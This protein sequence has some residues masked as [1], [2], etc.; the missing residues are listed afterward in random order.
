M[1]NLGKMLLF[2]VF[3]SAAMATSHAQV[4]R[5]ELERHQAPVNF[6]NFEGPVI[7]NETR[8]QI[9]QIGV[10]LGQDIAAGQTQAGTLGWYFVISSVS[11]PD[12]D[13][14]NAD[15]FGIGAGAAVDH[16][17]N[18]RVIIQGY[19]QAAYNY[20]EADAALLSQFI[21]IY[22]AVNRADWDFIS[23]RYKAPV[24][25]HLTPQN[26]GISV[27]FDEW[28]GQ[29]RMLIPIAGMGDLSAVDTAAISDMRVIDEL[30]TE[31]GM[32]IE[33]RMDLVDLMEREAAE[34]EARAAALR[35]AAALEEQA[36]AQE[37][38]RLEAEQQRIA[39]EQQQLA[40]A[41]AASEVTPAQA[42]QAQAAIAQAQAAAAAQEQ[43]I[44]QQEAAVAAQQAAAAQQ[45]QF[46]EQRFDDA[47]QHREAIAQ[48][49]QQIIIAQVGLPP[50][51]PPTLQQGFLTV[52]IERPG[53]TMGRLVSIDP[54]TRQQRNSPLTTVQARTLTFVDGRLLAIAGER[55]GQ[56]AVRL[57]EIDTRNMEMVSQG[58]DDIHPGSLIWQN[59]MYLYAI[60]ADHANG[61]ALNLG[62]FDRNLVL[63]ARSD[64]VLH[65]NASISIQQGSLMTQRAD[66]TAA[67]LHPAT[68]A[69]N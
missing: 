44:A 55:V 28:A 22:N 65:P 67:V 57:V 53:S 29:T 23:G 42:A 46:A 66:G 31:D 34:A 39:Q 43:A 32:G 41:Q 49:Q 17:R 33:L 11:P 63:Q 10:S 58:N 5:A 19:L 1:K 51:L 36:L 35:Q 27:R 64:V 45:E 21:T 61:G 9:R 15:I 38:A 12:G 62:R 16:I 4:D 50:Q 60:T 13:R 7:R 14:L 24:L 68:L 52:V 20:S 40:Q 37:R 2:C 30:R 54:T 8:E 25:G 56:G 59:G 6:V 18:L 69:E 47:Q 48:D 26:V 3:F